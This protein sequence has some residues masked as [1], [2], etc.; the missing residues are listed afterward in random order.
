MATEPIHSSLLDTQEAAKYTGFSKSAFERFRQEDSGPPYFILSRNT[1]RYD[2][3]DLDQWV[4]SRRVEPSNAQK[5]ESEN[6]KATA[7]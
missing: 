5:S 4:R 2:R 7:A 3:S 1:V 6:E